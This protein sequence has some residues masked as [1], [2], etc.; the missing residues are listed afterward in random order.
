MPREVHRQTWG[1]PLFEIIS[2]RSPGIDA[3]A[4]RRTFEPVI[5]EYVRAGK[6]DAISS[7]NFRAL[8][9][10]LAEDRRL[11]ILTSR[12]HTELKHLLEPDHELGGRITAFYYR[13][14]ME[15]HKPDP[16]AF[17][18][19]LGNYSLKSASCAYVGDSPSDAAAANG[20]GMHFIAS[21]ESGL[22]TREDFREFKV[23]VFIQAFAEVVS[24]V[25]QLEAA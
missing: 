6:L 15:F 16:R 21:L 17:T 4:F 3:R 5:N 1:K 8:D 19:L 10:L 9:E 23:D 13:D 2:T 24:A 11:F 25:Q 22:R 20:A 7:A 12:T 18:K 14:N